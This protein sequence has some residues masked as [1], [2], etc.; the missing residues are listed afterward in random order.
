MARR[1]Y[2]V[3]LARPF[4]VEDGRKTVTIWKAWCPV[5]VKFHEHGAEPDHR[6]DHCIEGPFKESRYILKLDPLMRAKKN[7]FSED[8]EK[9]S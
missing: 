6:A 4:D 8:S 9:E 2:P 1:K 3:L 7:C 5:C